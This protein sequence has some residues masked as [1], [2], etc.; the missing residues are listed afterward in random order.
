MSRLLPRFHAA[1]DAIEDERKVSR[2]VSES[3]SLDA[4]RISNRVTL[5]GD[6]RRLR[7]IPMS[8]RGVSGTSPGT[9]PLAALLRSQKSER[10]LPF[11]T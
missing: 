6:M 4:P 8:A 5:P 7:G 3:E 11:E 1:A 2:I 9:S 10:I